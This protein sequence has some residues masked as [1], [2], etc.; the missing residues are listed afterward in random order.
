MEK[1]QIEPEKQE[2]NSNEYKIIKSEQYNSEI[3]LF[4]SEKFQK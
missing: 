2:S 3:I 4:V 1:K